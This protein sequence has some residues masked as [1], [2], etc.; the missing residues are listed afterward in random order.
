MNAP[1]VIA[2][3][4]TGGHM[5]PGLA[6]A[7]VLEGRGHRTV[8]VCD[9]RGARFVPEDVDCRVLIAGSPS[10]GA[11]KR[12]SGFA[13]LGAGFAQALWLLRE[14][15]P[16]AVASF[17]SYACVPTAL[18]AQAMRVP[19]LV[20]EQNALLGRA[21]RL[22]AK[23]AAMV[24]LS[25]E[26]IERV[27]TVPAERRVVTGNPVRPEVAALFG[28]PYEAPAAGGLLRVL[29]L[30]GSQGARVFSDLLPQAFATL[31]QSLR[32]RLRLVQQCRPEDIERVTAAYASIGIEAELSTFFADAPM[33]MAASH[34]VVS[35]SGGS[36]VAELVALGRPSL[37][38]P[39]PQSI[40]G[41]QRANA[42]VLAKAGAAIVLEGDDLTPAGFGARLCT[43]LDSPAR[44]VDMA[45]A[46]A[47]L[48]RPDAARALAEAVVALC[49]QSV[50]LT[51]T[52]GG[53]L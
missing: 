2:G 6:C 29:V 35:R 8:V 16:V 48:A 18:A 49:R 9:Q 25:F 40:E 43:C 47:S 28:T 10:G 31:P 27:E 53:A 21:N 24:A 45:G 12:L 23:R 42:H 13:H 36:S 20:H 37:L 50:P 4:G 46:A 30:G 33:R 17:G 22:V 39:L 7:R 51:A 15:R 32:A 3:G 44:L 11:V 26:Q 38:A 34:L 1:I 52:Y 19:V 5:F 14:L 41:D